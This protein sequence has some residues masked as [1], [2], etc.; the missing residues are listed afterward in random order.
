MIYQIIGWVCLG[1][2]LILTIIIWV[3]PELKNP[4]PSFKNSQNKRSNKNK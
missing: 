2:T 4:P 1:A 3:I